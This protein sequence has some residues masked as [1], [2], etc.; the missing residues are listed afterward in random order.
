MGFE[1]FV[2]VDWGHEECE[3]VAT[4]QDGQ[5][6][7]ARRFKADASGVGELCQMAMKAGGGNPLTV[8]V[9]IECT[10]GPVVDALMAVGFEVCHVNPKKVDRGRE[11]MSMSGAK[12]DRRDAGVIAWMLRT[13]PSAFLP[14]T[15]RDPRLVE[16]RRASRIDQDT[17]AKRRAVCN[18]IEESVRSY[19]PVLLEIA[20][21][22]AMWFTAL[23]RLVQDPA[24]A[25]RVP[26]QAIAD[27]LK[28]HR[29]RKHTAS[30]VVA[31]LRAPAMVV[32]RGVT[33]AAVFEL[34]LLCKQLDLLHAQ[35]KLAE[36][37]LEALL[38]AVKASD[39]EGSAS[40]AALA[41]SFPGIGTVVL[42]SMIGEGLLRLIR[43]NLELARLVSGVAPVSKTTG[44]RQTRG[45]ADVSMRRACNRHLR[46]AMHWWS[47]K[48]IQN[49]P[50]SKARYRA[51]RARGHTHPRACRQ[52]AD[53]NLRR[54]HAMLRDRTFFQPSTEPLAAAQ[55]A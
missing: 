49:D 13:A 37:R 14:L 32:A 39:E 55:V 24:S 40:D 53:T 48:A 11:M 25:R 3:V 52:L 5:V 12:D 36:D 42:A 47:E 20:E 16:L 33:E 30:D 23:W 46:Q 9:G 38:T 35:V 7:F 19:F 10:G 44:K 2:G 6:S 51:L 43:E 18:Q 41:A 54:L 1:V 50:G 28:K 4:D 31:R 34:D 21:P 26:E 27:L 8:V 29:V 45:H 22:D 15:E 17:K